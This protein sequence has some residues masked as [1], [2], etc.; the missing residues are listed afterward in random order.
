MDTE[1]R[2]IDVIALLLGL[3]DMLVNKA[4]LTAAELDAAVAAHAPVDAE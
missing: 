2:E 4:V 3:R 1:D